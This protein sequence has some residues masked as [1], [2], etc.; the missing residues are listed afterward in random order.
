[1][2]PGGIADKKAETM[3]RVQKVIIEQNDKKSL[4]A[5]FLILTDMF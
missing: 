3:E 4:I 1:V 5:A 2:L